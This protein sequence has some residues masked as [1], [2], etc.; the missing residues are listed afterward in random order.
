MGLRTFWEVLKARKWIVLLALA[1]T[2]ITTFAASLLVTPRYEATATLVLDYDSSNPM[3]MNLMQMTGSLQSVEYMNTQIELIRSR[4][5]STG[6]IDLLGL[7][8][9]PGI[10]DAFNR[11]QIPNPV[12]FWRSEKNQDIKVWL[13]DSFLTRHLKVEP[14]R[15]AR[16]LYI[17]FSS[18]DPNF[19]AQVANAYAK[20]Y[21]ENN[22]EMKVMPFREA[23]KWFSAKLQDVKTKVDTSSE[24]LREYQKQ[25]GIIAHEGRYYDDAVQSL[26][27]LNRD[28]TAA[29]TKLYETR[30]A[31]R[32]V[33]ESRG[34]YESLPEVI[35]NAFIQNLKTER[36]RLETALSEF[37]GKVG[38]MHP[39]YLRTQSE[40]QMVNTKLAAEIKNLIDA[41]K[42]DH[43]SAEERVRALQAA[44]AGQK[45][46]A[47][48]LNISRYRMDS[49]N[50]ESEISNQV[51][52]AVLKKFNETA[53]QSDMSRT[54][55]FLVDAAV[56]PSE[57]SSPKLMLNMALA[58]FLGMFLGAGLAL[59]FEYLDDT[60]RSAE[61][62]ER[63]FGIPVLGTI[64]A[65]EKK[66]A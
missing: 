34:S 46:Q 14:A 9:A 55:V 42:K 18:A 51:Y 15:D 62:T 11:A 47:L 20:A 5:V 52:D 58:V 30:V 61:L 32:R 49:L 35:G 64:P 43:T 53:L 26:D 41:V 22:L 56:P 12:F 24:Q 7:D 57:K 39:Q 40:L 27:Q 45:S 1:T 29:K 28:L 33:E 6:V 13:A 8:R 44:V 23:E 4:K 31:M 19:S 16:F 3:N 66:T 50:R 60:V 54:N 37:S 21:A 65:A 25:K 63:S 48:N 59:F 36:I 10:I 2:V 38:P 17:R